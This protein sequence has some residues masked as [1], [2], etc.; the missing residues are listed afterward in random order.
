MNK[1][2][3]HHLFKAR[4]YI[5]QPTSMAEAFKTAGLVEG[6]IPLLREPKLQVNGKPIIADFKKGH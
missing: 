5:F 2:N 3:H 4:D 6:N 1:Q